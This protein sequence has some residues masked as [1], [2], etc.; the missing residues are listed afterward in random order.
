MTNTNAGL[1]AMTERAK[2]IWSLANGKAVARGANTV[3]GL[4]VVGAIVAH[5]N[6]FAAYVLRELNVR[7]KKVPQSFTTSRAGHLG[8]DWEGDLWAKVFFELVREQMRELRYN[9]CGAEV[10][11]LALMEHPDPSIDE[12]LSEAG[13]ERSAVRDL[14][15]EILGKKK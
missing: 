6:N 9:Y 13:V 7:Q 11:L 10:L 5:Y 2:T 3:E 12:V 4:D 14:A 1:P 8:A 15:L